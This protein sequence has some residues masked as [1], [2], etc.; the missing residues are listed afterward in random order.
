MIR[1]KSRIQSVLHANLIPRE[2]SKLYTKRGRVLL[3]RL[4][5]PAD[6]KRPVLRHQHEPDRLAPELA[7]LDRD[8]AGQALNDPNLKRLMTIGG[9]NAI[10]A[11]SV[12]AA[13]GDITRFS[14][15]EDLVSYFCRKSQL[16]VVWRPCRLPRAY[17]ERRRGAAWEKLRP[18]PVRS[19]RVRVSAI[20]GAI[21]SQQRA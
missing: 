11:T 19:L 2:A 18:E 15:P 4:P 1:L 12:L 9:V 8:L 20:P 3:E 17:H 6:Q 5:L 10:V 14:S 16:P 21:R 13:I 7:I